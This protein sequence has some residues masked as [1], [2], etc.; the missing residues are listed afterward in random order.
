[1]INIVLNIG[2][3]SNYCLFDFMIFYIK[4]QCFLPIQILDLLINKMLKKY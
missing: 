1:M 4:K 3:Q 2:I